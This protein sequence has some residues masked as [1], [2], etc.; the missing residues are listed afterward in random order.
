MIVRQA[1]RFELHPNNVQRT[2]LKKHVGAARFA[3]NWA[4]ERIK[5]SLEARTRDGGVKVPTAADLHREWNSW[6]RGHA[7]WWIEVSKCAPQEA[8]RDLCSGLRNFLDS[9]S[10]K[11]KGKRIGF[12]TFRKRGDKDRCRF[13]TGAI[14]VRDPRNVQLPRLGVLRTK[15][16]T[17]K[18]LSKIVH[19]SARIT[20]ATVSR[21]ADRWFVSFACEVRRADPEPISGPVV[22]V[23]LGLESFAVLSDGTR[24]EAPRPLERDLSRLRRLTRAHSRKQRG[25]NNRRKSALKLARC[26]RRIRNRRLDFLHKVTTHLART[27]SVVVI[28]DLGV[29]NMIRNHHLARHI[30][31]AGWGKFHRMLAYKTT[32][33][34]STV[35]V[36]DRF[37]P[38]SKTCSGCG[39]IKGDLAL[40]QRVYRCERCGL[41]I[42]RDLNAALNLVRYRSVAVSA[43]ETQ[44]ACGA[45]RFMASGQVPRSE[46][47]TEQPKVDLSLGAL[48]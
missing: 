10:G 47:G 37:Y 15:E 9:R 43:T 8:F 44:N 23:D 14:S 35:V 25:S 5:G 42:D 41:V 24:I 22:G 3:Y 2:A 28:E 19:G 13:S 27:K 34:G 48:V 26:H 18:L 20:S 38:S 33:Y 31:D 4:L 1:Y 39:A 7:P 30:A 16:P 29:Q 40:S 11:R 17:D 36:A 12:P 6:K 45:G 32:W 46:T 21:E